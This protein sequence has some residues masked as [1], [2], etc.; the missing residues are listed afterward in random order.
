MLFAYLQHVRAED[1]FVLVVFLVFIE[2]VIKV[3]ILDIRLH[4]RSCSVALCLL[5]GSR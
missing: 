4:G 2:G 3:Y 1:D 5:L